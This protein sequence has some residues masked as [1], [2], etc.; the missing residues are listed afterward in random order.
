[1]GV[2]VLP[3]LFSAAKLELLI[4]QLPLEPLLLLRLTGG[5]VRVRVRFRVMARVQ[6]HGYGHG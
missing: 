5:R 3:R 6:G 2:G 4:A 1:M